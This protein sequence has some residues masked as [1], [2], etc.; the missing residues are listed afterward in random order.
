MDVVIM[1]S[2]LHDIGR[3]EERQTPESCH[4]EIGSRKAFDF[5]LAQGYCEQTACHVAA[6]ILTHR[7]KKSRVPQ[8]IEAQIIFDADKLDLTGTVGT[9]RAILF[10]AQ[11]GEPLYLLNDRHMPA[12]GLPSDEASLFRE[13]HRKLKYLSGKLY[14]AKA[15][16]IAAE[17][18]KSMDA[19]FDH[20]FAEINENYTAGQTILKKLFP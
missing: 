5:L 19:Y 13:Y 17:Q 7:Y 9:A 16:C 14:T 1:A 8:S 10:G 18:Q 11:I 20:L 6:C 4:A 12:Q 2:L 3:A 15:R